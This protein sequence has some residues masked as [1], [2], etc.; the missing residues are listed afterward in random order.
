M[1]GS[2]RRLGRIYCAAVMSKRLRGDR[3]LMVRRRETDIQ[4]W[5]KKRYIEEKVGYHSFYS[6]RNTAII[7]LIISCWSPVRAWYDTDQAG[8]TGCN[9]EIMSL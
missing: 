7:R 3:G 1:W 5:E 6:L 2:N 8:A 4:R 9:Y